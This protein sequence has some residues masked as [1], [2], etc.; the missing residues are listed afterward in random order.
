MGGGNFRRSYSWG[1]DANGIVECRWTPT[2]KFVFE[3]FLPAKQGQRQK[4][5][6]RLK[7]EERTLVFFESPHRLLDMLEDLERIFGDRQI[8]IGRELTKMFE[9]LRRGVGERSPSIAS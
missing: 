6:E 4:V 5:L 2:D 1:I 7:Q 8:V 3:G 9:E